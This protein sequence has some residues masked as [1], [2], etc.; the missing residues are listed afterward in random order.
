MNINKHRAEIARALRNHR[1]HKDGGRIVLEGAA[2]LAIG[3]SFRHHDF[4]GD[5]QIDPNLI[6]TEGLIQ[7]LNSW[8]AGGAQ[9]SARYLAL[10]ENDYTPTD[11]LTAA[12]FAATAGEFEDI[13]SATRPVWSRAAATVT[14]EVGNAG[15][16]ATFTYATGGPYNIY[17]CAL[18][19]S[20]VKGGTAGHLVAATRFATSRLNQI[21][22]DRLGIEYVITGEDA[23]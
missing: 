14:P 13:T 11:D 8:L 15:S 19:S 9:V 12:T 16:E 22:G 6:V 10:F 21:A 1:F 3:G 17:G 4:R 2:R 7:G 20:S 23:S 18:L 5:V